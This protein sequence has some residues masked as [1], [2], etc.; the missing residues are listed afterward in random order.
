ME[1]RFLH[2]SDL[3]FKAGDRDAATVFAQDVVNRSLV[4]AAG[5]VAR[6]A[7][8]DFI[9]VTGDV[10]Y[11]AGAAEY[12]VALCFFERL[13]EATGVPRER[14]HVVPGNHDVDRQEVR[15]HHIR[16]LYGFASQ[17]EIAELLCDPDLSPPLHRKLAPYRAFAARAMGRELLDGATAHYFE[18]LR[19]D[20]GGRELRVNLLGLNSALFAGYDGDDQ[21]K[22]ALGLGQ[23]GTALGQ[24]DEGAPLTIALLHHPMEA[25]HPCD[26]PSL[27]KLK[28]HATLVLSGHVHE[29]RAAFVHD[30]AGL[31]TFVTA[32]SAF[33]RRQH[34]NGFNVVAV[35]LVRGAGCV[36]FYKYLPGHD[37]WKETSERA[38]HTED[39][40]F[41][42][43]IPAL[44]RD[45]WMPRVSTP[46]EPVT[47]VAPAA[48]RDGRPLVHWVHDILL[49]ES[50]TAREEELGRLAAIA[51]G[52]PDPQTGK[53]P[54]V[55]VVRGVGGVGKSCLARKHLDEQRQGSRFTDLLCFSFY[56]ARTEDPAQALRDMLARLDP[57]ASHE[58]DAVALRRRLCAVLDAR[59]VLLLLDGLEVIQEVDSGSPRHGALRDGHGETRR[60]LAHL[61]NQTTS[62]ALVTTRVPLT[63]LRGTAGS[64]EIPLGTLD[65]A[66][67][68]RLLTNLGVEGTQE[69]LQRCARLLGGHA[70]AL[71][72][73]GLWLA[74]R[75]LPASEIERLVGDPIVFE[76]SA[77]G[78]KVARIVQTIRRELSPEQVRFLRYLAVHTRPVTER[79]L[80]LLVA[81]FGTGGHDVRWVSEHVAAPLEQAGLIDVARDGGA[82]TWHAHPLMKLAFSAWFDGDG[83]RAAHRDWAKA[84]LGAP[85]C[86]ARPA[87]ATSLDGLQPYLDAVEHYLD[88]EDWAEAWG[89]FGD[90]ESR[91]YHLGYAGR[92]LALGER[93]EDALGRGAW[94]PSALDR[95]FLHLHLG[96][97]HAARGRLDAALENAAGCSRHPTRPATKPLHWPVERGSP[98]TTSAWGGWSR[99]T[100][101]WK[102][103]QGRQPM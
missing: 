51:K 79:N 15:P 25:M 91:L 33:E 12:E 20:K 100:R 65:E 66:D 31:A 13:L 6:E 92:L 83:A 38:P 34:D 27:N 84:A 5:S 4:E 43:G 8:L 60:L 3:H 1:L 36:T 19:L 103:W 82:V 9:A 55:V 44:A 101:R 77:E 14:L 11:S 40:R 29:G 41:R 35:D 87:D 26:E 74:T 37:L 80:G 47:V 86:I 50:F 95:V 64:L 7:P 94:R 57:G 75:H 53:R 30:V 49:P 58:G 46:P 32:G 88:A 52:E 97:A 90:V 61:A 81:G 72:A 62:L 89:V 42:F 2:I 10:A 63:D 85:D 56:E 21:R 73:A 96:A 59:P 23:V 67:A 22:L 16:R 69:D 28:Q 76:R 99:R 102:P 93:F 17:E 98:P 78:E 39:G 48:S 18:L 54:G 45:P 71:R 68:A 70:L 24:R